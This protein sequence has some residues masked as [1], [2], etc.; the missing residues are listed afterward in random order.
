MKIYVGPA[1]RLQGK[2]RVPPSKNYTSRYI[3]VSALA[4]G[5]SIIYDPATNDD[6][7]ALLACCQRLGAKVHASP[8]RLQI[9]GFG[10]SPQPPGV[11]DPGNGGLILRLLLPVGLL[12][13][14]VQYVTSYPE[15]L[16]KR[17]QDHLLTALRDLGA[18][19][20]DVDGHLP[21]TI[22]GGRPLARRT[23][24]VSGR[25]SSQFA[26]ALLMIAPLLG[27]LDL[28]ITEGLVSRPPLATTLQVM[29]E[30]GVTPQADW[31]QLRFAVAAGNYKAGVYHVPGDYPAASAIMAAAAL[32]PSTV[33]L[34]PL[35]PA[36][37]QGEKQ[38]IP[39]LQQL[40]VAVERESPEVTIRGGSPLRAIDFNGEEAIDAVLSMAAVACCAE[41]TTTF[42]QVANLRW[43]E[44]DR[45]GD[46]AHGLRQI[47]VAITETADGFVITGNPE[48]YEGGMELDGCQDHRLIMT[49]AVLALRTQKGLVISG[50][51]HVSKSFPDF[52][53]ALAALGATVREVK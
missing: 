25:I 1:S 39:Y 15:S 17:P 48:G 44:S 49:Y 27:G 32:V 37:Q 51:E 45:I 29:T 10:R 36:D 16:G 41:G 7:N 26:S 38:V 42:S 12:L 21:I 47:G 11:L 2:V 43:K 34:Y 8:G 22:R 5:E 9:S 20:E 13:P 28:Q 4:E 6:A 33:T 19:V 35:N 40:G 14:E 30:A 18:E 52:F 23:V 31:A 24:A 46:L 3:W 53:P 50:A